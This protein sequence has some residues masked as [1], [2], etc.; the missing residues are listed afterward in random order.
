[1]AES[2]A[3]P[4]EVVWGDCDAILPRNDAWGLSEPTSRIVP[5]QQAP[6]APHRE[7]DIR[8]AGGRLRLKMVLM[9]ALTH[10]KVSSVKCFV[11]T[12][13]ILRTFAG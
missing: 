9:E 11:L 12:C 10:L 1:M 2:H 4:L 8:E 13:W 3:Q 7:R 6:A 5:E